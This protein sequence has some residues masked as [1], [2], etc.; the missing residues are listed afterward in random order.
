[1]GKFIMI[2]CFC[3]RSLFVYFVQ[4]LNVQKLI[5]FSGDFISVAIFRFGKV[6]LDYFKISACSAGYKIKIQIKL[7]GLVYL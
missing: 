7:K 1:M 5:V 3:V 6:T 2:D 4:L